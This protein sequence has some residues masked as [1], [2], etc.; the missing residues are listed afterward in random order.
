MKPLIALPHHTQGKRKRKHHSGLRGHQR[1]PWRTTTRSLA[2]PHA[3]EDHRRSLLSTAGPGLMPSGCRRS[4][5]LKSASAR[6]RAAQRCVA[7]TGPQATN[8]RVWR[9]GVPGLTTELRLKASGATATL[10]AQALTGR[11]RSGGWGTWPAAVGAQLPGEPGGCCRCS[12]GRWGADAG[13]EGSGSATNWS[14]PVHAVRRF[15]GG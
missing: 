4:P 7:Q 15:T 5:L 10:L 14:C 8:P 13:A 12:E 11:F 2:D 1:S 3:T 9:R 6:T